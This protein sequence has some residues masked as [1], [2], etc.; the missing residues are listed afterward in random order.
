MKLT[1]SSGK[2]LPTLFVIGAV[3][4]IVREPAK[5]AHFAAAAMDGLMKVADSLVTFLS[6]FG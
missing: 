3:F 1:T 4:F 6:N 5:A 2:F